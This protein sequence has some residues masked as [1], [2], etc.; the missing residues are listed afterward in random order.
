M[1][2]NALGSLLSQPIDSWKDVSRAKHAG[3]GLI[4]W[5]EIGNLPPQKS[6]SVFPSLCY[7]SALLCCGNIDVIDLSF[8]Y[9][10]TTLLSWFIMQHRLSHN[11]LLWLPLIDCMSVIHLSPIILQS[12]QKIPI[13]LS[14]SRWV[15]TGLSWFGYAWLI[16]AGF[17]YASPVRASQL[18]SSAHLG[19]TIHNLGWFITWSCLLPKPGWSH[20]GWLEQLGLV[21]RA[22]SS[23]MLTYAHSSRV[24]G[25]GEE[26]NLL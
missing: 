22:R 19:W 14:S 6:N 20:L 17:T 9:I 18:D 23:N 5:M 10:L 11:N 1:Q 8:W 26:S 4:D 13:Y 12:K 24:T 21:P 15:W 25:S 3:H 7:W 16:S 2:T